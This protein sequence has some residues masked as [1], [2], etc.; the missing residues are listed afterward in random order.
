[1]LLR[2]CDG[3][4][5]GVLGLL[6]HV[7]IGTFNAENLF[8]RFQFKD[9]IPDDELPD[10]WTASVTQCIPFSE[11]KDRITAQAIGALRADILG[12]QEVE[13]MDT[14]KQFVRQFRPLMPDYPYKLVI[15]GND[16]RLIDVGLLS[17][18]PFRHIRTHQFDRAPSGH[19]IFSRDCLEVDIE[20]PDSKLLTV[21]VNHFKSMHEG[22]EETMHIRKIQTQRVV[23]IL[24]ERFGADPGA[25]KWVVLGDFNDYMPSL[26]LEPLLSQPWLENVIERLHPDQRWTHFFSRGGDYHQLDYIL[27]S[28]SLA[29]A[30]PQALPYIERRG[31]P[32]RADRTAV[33]RFNGVGSSYPKASDH[34][35]VVIEIEV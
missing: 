19:L 1:V 11:G 7:R 14:L 28:R 3:F 31:L 15:D 25:A 21:F 24:H 5:V 12:L 29:E 26:G 17:R 2:R 18:Y 30:N 32:K 23:Q 6:M 20:L 33:Q 10:K 27:L 9:D 16:R 13:S 22:R 8:A 4:R 34:C 35:P